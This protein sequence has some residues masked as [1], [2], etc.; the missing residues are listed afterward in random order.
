MALVFKSNERNDS[1]NESGSVKKKRQQIKL[2]KDGFQ[3]VA[4]IKHTHT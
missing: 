1:N 3:V 4:L 2:N